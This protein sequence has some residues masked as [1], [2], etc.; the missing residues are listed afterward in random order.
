MTQDVIDFRTRTLMPEADVDLI[1]A[2]RSGYLESAVA[3]AIKEI[4]SRLRKRYLTPFD[5]AGVVGGPNPRLE[6]ILRWLTMI[7][8]PEAYR[9]RGYNPQDPTMD[10]VEKDRERAYEQIKEAADEKD[11]L[12]DLPLRDSGDASGVIRGGPTGYSEPSPYDWR[13]VQADAINARG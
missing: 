13:D 3:G 10:Q 8:T 7:V 12:Y 11:G 9:A 2:Q 1:W 5:A 6:I 4:E